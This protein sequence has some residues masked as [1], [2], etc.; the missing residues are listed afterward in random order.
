MQ[1]TPKVSINSTSEEVRSTGSNDWFSAVSKFPLIQLPRKSEAWKPSTQAGPPCPKVSINSTSEEV[2]SG[3]R[4]G[5]PRAGSFWFPLIQ[6]P[7]KSEVDR[8]RPRC[9][10]CRCV[11]INS[12]SE[13]VRSRRNGGK[14]GAGWKFPLIQLPRKSED[15]FVSVMVLRF[16]LCNVQ[17]YKE[18][19][20]YRERHLAIFVNYFCLE[21]TNQLS[22]LPDKDLVD[23]CSPIEPYQVTKSL[24]Y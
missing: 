10:N 16:V 17:D 2:R 4:L 23:L 12:T 3:K 14:T 6:L 15:V 7:R 24:R 13:E 1:N 22:L 11:S 8:P 9:A 19:N 21:R 18:W 20:S 5:P